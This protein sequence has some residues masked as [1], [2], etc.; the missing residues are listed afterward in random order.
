MKSD[1]P[2]ITPL[3]AEVSGAVHT[4]APTSRGGSPAAAVVVGGLKRLCEPNGIK[5]QETAKPVCVLYDNLS[6]VL[7][8]EISI[9][10]G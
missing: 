8:R 1:V 6:R 3:A 2:V 10:R 9:F 7:H 5:V 4:S